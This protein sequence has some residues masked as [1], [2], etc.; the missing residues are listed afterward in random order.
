MRYQI[1]YPR[2]L[3]MLIVHLD[4]KLT[5]KAIEIHMGDDHLEEASEDPAPAWLKEIYELDGIQGD[6]FIQRYELHVTK[7]T[8]FSWDAI[9]PKIMEI[10]RRYLD[11]EGQAIEITPP[12]QWTADDEARYQ[13]WEL[14]SELRTRF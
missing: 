8:V 2:N 11:P 14:R 4:Q 10:L 13:E 3:D 5:N 9:T 1:E 6:S 7:A 12:K